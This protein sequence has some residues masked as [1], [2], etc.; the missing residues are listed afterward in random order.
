MQ[1]PTLKKPTMAPGAADAPAIVPVQLVIGRKIS[2][3]CLPS[4]PSPGLIYLTRGEVPDPAVP[5]MTI[6]PGGL[7]EIPHEHSGEAWTAGAGG[8]A[9]LTLTEYG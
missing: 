4:S 6:A 3:H 2:L 5:T 7:Y 9:L 1:N 8:A